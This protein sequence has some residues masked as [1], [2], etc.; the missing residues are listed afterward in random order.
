MQYYKQGNYLAKS[1]IKE[2]IIIF[3]EKCW[4]SIKGLETIISFLK[5]LLISEIL[6]NYIKK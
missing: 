1:Y 3:W 4:G 6:L 2:G 5:K